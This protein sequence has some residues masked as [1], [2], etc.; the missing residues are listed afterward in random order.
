[1]KILEYSA[2]ELGPTKLLV[3]NGNFNFELS[4]KDSIYQ[5]LRYTDLP[6]FEDKV[7]YRVGTD[8]YTLIMEVDNKGKNFN[9]RWMC[10]S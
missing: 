6:K 9:L 10:I 8:V 1:M 5:Y 4:D 7:R 2:E 3:I